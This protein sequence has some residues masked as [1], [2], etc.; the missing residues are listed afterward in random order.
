[1]RRL[2]ILEDIGIDDHVSSVVKRDL[3]SLFVLANEQNRDLLAII[4]RQFADS[5]HVLVGLPRIDAQPKLAISLM[6]NR[7]P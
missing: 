6:H 2:Y 3:F 4:V 5:S 7:Q 1:M